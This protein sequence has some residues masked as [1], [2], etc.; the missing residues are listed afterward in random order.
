MATVA[1]LGLG[2]MGTGMALRLASAGHRLNVY[3]RTASKAGELVAVGAHACST[4]RAACNGA[5]AV[6]AMVS[7]D[8]ASRAVWLGADG[9]LAGA[10]AP[11][12][13]AIECSTLSR[14]WVLELAAEAATRGL[15]YL[16]APV[17]GLPHAARLGQLT[18]LIGAATNDL[19][20]ARSLLSPLAERVFRELAVDSA[21]SN[22]SK[23]IDVAR[24]R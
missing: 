5:D 8:L 21:D 10:L 4:P 3:A 18:L 14:G 19:D 1:F 6:F 20:A 17:T 9:A 2:K 22:E 7:D 16:D 23:V 13:F 24:R 12:A 11:F 15:R